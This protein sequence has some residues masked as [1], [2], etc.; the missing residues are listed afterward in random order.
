MDD[1]AFIAF[2][3]DPTITRC[4]VLPF[5]AGRPTQSRQA[6]PESPK[7]AWRNGVAGTSGA[8]WRLADARHCKCGNLPIQLE[9]W[10]AKARAHH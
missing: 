2:P 8:E 6:C 3:L 9:D 4:M 7:N 1:L 10:L 5:L